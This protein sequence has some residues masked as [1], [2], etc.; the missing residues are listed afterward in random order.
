MTVAQTPH[1][2][3]APC[4]D[5]VRT[6]RSAQATTVILCDGI[7]SGYFANI[8]A[9]MAAARFLELIEGF[10]LRE[11]FAR[12][13]QTM[14]GNRAPSRPYAALT[15]LRIRSSGRATIL[16][17]DM[18]PPLYLDGRQ[19]NR[20]EQRTIQVEGA[21]FQEAEIR[22]D[23]GEAL[24]AVSDGITEAGRGPGNPTG[25]GIEGVRGRVGDMLGQR[26]ALKDIPG[27]V[28]AMA[29]RL[30]GDEP[31][32]TTVVTAACVRGREVV[33]FTGPPRERQQD[34]RVV[35][36]F[37]AEGGVKIVCGGSTA[38][39]VARTLG[40]EVRVE[41]E[42]RDPLTP[43]RLAI[44]GVD[45]VTEGV[46]TLNQ[47]YNLLDADMAD[48]VGDNPAVEVALHLQLADCVRFYMGRAVNDASQSRAFRQ[49]GL[50]DRKGIVDLLRAKLELQG[51]LVLVQEF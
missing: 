21:R 1:H 32:D 38:G 8:A 11:A 29:W 40:Q 47:V 16:G 22:L 10:T 2:A 7:R 34:A 41:A 5:V 31:D 26:M 49:Q 46:V 18:P 6:A 37:L 24:L 23:P 33:L 45:L 50:I 51:K 17:Y 13:V 3:G 14:E 48:A 28:E 4:G 9:E 36:R 19:A 30:A 12:L 25:W 39:L 42:S 27:A 15:A 44:E 35:S 20:L 43:P